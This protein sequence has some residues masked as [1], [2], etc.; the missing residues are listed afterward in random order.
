MT[1]TTPFTR[2]FSGRPLH[3]DHRSSRTRSQ[4]LHAPLH[5]LHALRPSRPGGSLERTPGGIGTPKTPHSTERSSSPGADAR[6]ARIVHGR[7]RVRVALKAA[8]ETATNQELTH[9]IGR[10]KTCP[11]PGSDRSHHLSLS[12]SPEDGDGQDG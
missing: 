4:T 12:E 10:R 11:R 9:A 5:D 2:V 7:D 1:F 8:G 3:A 6:E